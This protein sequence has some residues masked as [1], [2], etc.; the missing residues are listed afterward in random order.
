MTRTLIVAVLFVLAGSQRPALDPRLSTFDA[1][2]QRAMTVYYG[3]PYGGGAIAFAGRRGG[4]KLRGGF[5]TTVAGATAAAL[6][7]GAKYLGQVAA[8]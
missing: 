6:V 3:R 2:V 1:Y 4:K 7:P 5:G 8:R